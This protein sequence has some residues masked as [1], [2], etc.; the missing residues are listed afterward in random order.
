VLL[1]NIVVAAAP[2]ILKVDTADESPEPS[3]IAT[4]SFSKTSTS[5]DKE[6]DSSRSFEDNVKAME[7]E[8]EGDDEESTDFYSDVGKSTDGETVDVPRIHLN[9]VRSGSDTDDSGSVRSSSRTLSGY[10]DPTSHPYEIVRSRNA[11]LIM[12][13]KMKNREISKSRLELE[14]RLEETRKKLQSVS[15]FINFNINGI[16]ILNI[17]KLTS[18]SVSCVDWI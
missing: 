1:S 13:V 5:S 6:G 15:Y 12:S 8:A 14:K 7:R 17:V 3:S 11:E 9:K 18:N 10:K 16:H 2:E 4:E